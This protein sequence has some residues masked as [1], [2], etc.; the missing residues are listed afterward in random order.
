MN[1]DNA[2][3]IASMNE[4]FNP[5]CV[6]LKNRRFA[7]L[8]ER[9]L[10][11]KPLAHYYD[12]RPNFSK[13][14]ELEK[15]R[16]FLD[17]TLSVLGAQLTAS[18]PEQ[19]HQIPQQGPLLV[20]CNH[21]LGGLEGVAL[22]RL[23]LQVRD[24]VKV[25][26]NQMLTQIPE[27]S[28]LFIGVDVLSKNAAKENARG[29]RAAYQH[30][31]SGGVLLMFPAGMV[32]AINVDGV[33]PKRWSI[34]D[35]PWNV[36]LG[37]LV[38]KF[39]A[40]CLP[41][42]VHGR[43]SFKFYM[44]G[45]IHRR[46][47]TALLVRELAN[48]NGKNIQFDI[49]ALVSTQELSK[50]TSDRAIT[51][52]LRLSTD[53]LAKNTDSTNSVS[54]NN[55]V[56]EPIA[57]SG[58][59]QQQLLRDLQSLSD[60]RL[61]QHNDFSAY[62]APYRRLGS[63]MTAIAQAREIT[64][65]AAGEGTGKSLDSDHFD[66]HYDHLFIWDNK[67][68]CIVG[69]YRLGRAD[70]I[71]AQYGINQL[72]SR[73]LYYFN[74]EYLS[75]LGGALEVGRSFVAPAYQRHPRALDMLWQGIG[76]YMVKNTRYHT[77][78]GC[79]SISKEHSELARAFLS[80]SMLESFRAEQRFL[81]DV[82]P[83]APLKVRGKLWSAEI[84]A[85]LTDIAV[86]NKLLGRFD[87]GK[88]VPILLRHYLNLNGRFVCFSLNKGFN[89]SL[90]G[91]ILVDLRNTSEKYLR[92]YLGKEGSD[93]FLRRWRIQSS[94]ELLPAQPLKENVKESHETAA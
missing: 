41:M 66:P 25:L 5:F 67:A 1:A 37:R 80:D 76:A 82:K 20:I 2:T 34:G 93:E 57:M 63:V 77:L 16:Q 12:Q 59:Q 6:P 31:A 23:L 90:D 71:V 64:F 88:T 69:G 21:P 47:R 36:L 18:N 8:L 85:S 74:E 40:P 68:Q 92:R 13:L 42:Y 54:S 45:L 3:A 48:K 79:V 26:T 30:L 14:N 7:R 22:T 9:V 17:Y 4:K 84:L 27:L 56:Q 46:L 33:N 87:A 11:L 70:E 83:V 51:H 94:S 28:N 78:F 38:Q 89:N 50:L 35:R 58:G 73:S 62:C 72:Y 32:S 61:A 55:H 43:N 60:C 86:I 29:V 44:L 91:L 15:S 52:Y 53:L 39:N 65:R 10:G 24:D 19:L 49:G 81:S 75:R